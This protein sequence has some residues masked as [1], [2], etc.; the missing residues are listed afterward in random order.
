MLLDSA[1]PG[2][3]QNEARPWT[4]SLG[5]TECCASSSA[6]K[7]RARCRRTISNSAHPWNNGCTGG[8]D[9]LH[10]LSARTDQNGGK[11]AVLI[12]SSVPAAISGSGAEIGCDQ[13]HRHR[14]YAQKQTVLLWDERLLAAVRLPC[15]DEQRAGRLLSSRPA[16]VTSIDLRLEFGHE[17]EF[18]FSRFLTED[19]DRV[20]C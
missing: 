16:A 4:T 3:A 13:C 12:R 7:S 15:N 2:G 9:P 19:R 11:P 10:K 1:P 14:I 17:V 8:P 20:P 5:L 18:N 6:A